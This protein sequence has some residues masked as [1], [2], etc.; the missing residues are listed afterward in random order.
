MRLRDFTKANL[1]LEINRVSRMAQIKMKKG[2][3]DQ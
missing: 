3:V 1:S 2:V